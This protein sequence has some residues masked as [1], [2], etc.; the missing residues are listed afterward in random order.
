VTNADEFANHGA[1]PELVE[2]GPFVFDEYHSK[3]G[4]VWNDNGTVTYKQVSEQ[5]DQI[6]RF[7]SFGYCSKMPHIYTK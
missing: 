7:L 2:V 4:L 3:V 1:K 5:G 6:G